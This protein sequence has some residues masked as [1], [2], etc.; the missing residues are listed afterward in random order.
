MKLLS[1]KEVQDRK[2]AEITRDIGRTQE[3]KEVLETVTKQLEEANAKFNVVMANQRIRWALEEE[4]H[5]KKILSLKK[6]LALLE[7][8]KQDVPYEIDEVKSY[9][10]D[11]E[12]DEIADLLQDKLDD[13]SER[14]Q[15]LDE[16][17][18]LLFIREKACREERDMI[19]RISKELSINLPKI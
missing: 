19:A 12:A 18:Q 16:R 9:D 10:K 1:Q 11:T 13:V 8:R 4:E 6:E 15:S 14:E 17:E 3:V 7:S 5:I 2:Q